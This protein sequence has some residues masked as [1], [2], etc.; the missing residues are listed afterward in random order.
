MFNN[1]PKN[2]KIKKLEQLLTYYIGG[3]W[4]EGEPISDEY[5]PV[6]IIRATDLTNWE[7]IMVK[8]LK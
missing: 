6:K 5:T 3:D 8:M 2:W 4:G 7:R 1:I